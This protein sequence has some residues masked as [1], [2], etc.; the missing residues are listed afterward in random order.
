MQSM[1]NANRASIGGL[2]KLGEGARTTN[3]SRVSAGLSRGANLGKKLNAAPWSD[4]FPAAGSTLDLDF[5][6]NRGFVRGVG[7]GGVM[8]AIT[9]TRASNGT[10]VN[11]QGLLVTHANQG[12]LGN[13]LLTFPQDFDNAVWTKS[14][15]T[16]TTKAELAPDNTLSADLITENTTLTTHRIFAQPSASGQV[17]LSVYAKNNVGS[18]YL[19][20]GINNGTVNFSSAVFDL[21]NGTNTQTQVSGTYS[22]ESASITTDS[23]GYYRC[24]LTVTTDTASF[25]LIGLVPTSTVTSQD[26]GF[27][28][29]YLGDG[30]SGIFIWG[31]Q[32]E[33]GS[34]ATEYFP[35]NIGQPRFDWA[36]TEQIAPVAG[37]YT[38]TTATANTFNLLT[39]SEE[40][41][42]SDWIKLNST[43]NLVNVTN[44]FGGALS[45][46]A[47]ASTSIV[48]ANHRISQIS[49][50]SIPSKYTF[51]FFAKA[52]EFGFVNCFIRNGTDT[53][54]G[55]VEACFDL[56][57]GVSTVDAMLLG[58]SWSNPVANIKEFP[59]GSGW[60]RCSLTADTSGTATKTAMICLSN[61]TSF[62]S[63]PAFAGNDVD[64]IYIWAAQ[65]ETTASTIPLLAN[66]TSNGLLIEQARTNRLFWNRDATQT[67]WVKTNVTA[68]KDQTG[69]DGV[70]NAASSLTATAN[71]GTCI[72]TITLASGNRTG[73]VFLKR[74]TGTG[75]IQVTLDGST[76]ST[77]ELSDTLWY[78]IVLSGNVTNPTVGI[79]LAVSGDAVAMD[80]SQVEDGLF[81]TSPILTTT[82]TVTRAAEGRSL[83]SPNSDGLFNQIEGSF[84][85]LLEPITDVMNTQIFGVGN[86]TGAGANG[87][88]FF[89]GAVGDRF[90]LVIRIPGLVIFNEN[91][92]GNAITK[93]KICLSGGWG[94]TIIRASSTGVTRENVVF[95]LPSAILDMGIWNLCPA[96]A[97]TKRLIVYP[98]N[99]NLDVITT[100][101]DEFNKT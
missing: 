80:Y 47:V 76:Y 78:R 29:A 2:A 81:A 72:Q 5:A 28:A 43:T 60:Y 75:N 87:I 12:A 49:T 17:T 98:K 58:A 54:G 97:T 82:A 83:T 86:G 74:I 7:Q 44:P 68:A 45:Y 99:T 38:Q 14:N 39:Y 51:S 22:A 25:V 11:E 56:A 93:S 57:T 30:E 41:D 1:T 96:N 69:I 90:A 89:T 31:A 101:I 61:A 100:N 16:I 53:T 62:T 35:T 13:N 18:R 92:F 65:L 48:N 52:N 4:T 37:N 95:A 34:T 71:D 3:D 88:N 40:F 20:I 85:M 79:R 26:R 8:D 23:N 42:N 19:A 59:I 70:A 6:N 64:S 91:T 33:V 73:S 21:S 32:L 66:P 50:T 84:L 10:Y 94:K 15:V 63:N 24:S 36:S 46:Q 67:E 55:I 27:G 9:F 77:V